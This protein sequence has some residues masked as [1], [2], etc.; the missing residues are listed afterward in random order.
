MF[1]TNLF[2]TLSGFILLLVVLIFVHELG[3]FLVAKISGVG[4]LKFSLGFGP[5]LIGRKYGE[6]EYIISAIPLGGYVKLLGESENDEISVE[7]ESRSFLKQ[8]ASKRMC[9]VAAGPLFNFL[10]AIVAFTFVYMIGVPVMTAEIGSIQKGSVAE[11]AG[12]L[13]GDKVIKIDGHEISD[14]NDIS[15]QTTNSHGREMVFTIVR[16][17]SN[18][19]V[20]VKPQLMKG[21]NI[22]GEKVESYKIGISPSDHVIS[23]KESPTD[24][25]QSGLKQTWFITELTAVSLVKMVEGVVSPKTLGGP[26]MIAQLAGTQV[27][28]GAVSFIFLMG[29]LSVN[30]AILN[31]LPIPVLDGGHIFFNLIEMIIGREISVKWREI[32]QQ[33]GFFLLILLMLFVFYNDILRIFNGG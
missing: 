30:L 5:K 7:D 12:F 11:K 10:F 1:D 23:R 3:H 26:I 31:L 28:K 25:V 32:A 16:G 27:K 14:W 8:S 13:K 24:A 29:L 9:I 20:R 18:L 33:I 15:D 19:S 21:N 6:T 4:V 22:F 17:P 2:Y